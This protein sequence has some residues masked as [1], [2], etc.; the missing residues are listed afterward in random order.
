MLPSLQF[1]WCCGRKQKVKFDCQEGVCQPDSDSKDTYGDI[2]VAFPN[3]S[4]LAMILAVLSVTTAT[5]ERSFSS[6]KL[7]KT[8]L[9]SRMGED[10]LETTMCTALKAQIILIS[11]TS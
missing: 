11:K 6:M 10:T 8:M 7:I 4:N 2:A 9:L 5:V 3:L 1:L